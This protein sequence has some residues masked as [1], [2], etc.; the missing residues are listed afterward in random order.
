MVNLQGRVVFS[1]VVKLT[2]KKTNCL[3]LAKGIRFLKLNGDVTFAT[4]KL[5]IDNF[6]VNSQI[7]Y[8]AYKY[9]K[10]NPFRNAVVFL[11]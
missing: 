2:G 7:N 9:E 3:S 1:S 5:I 6:I 10:F 8:Y 4:Q 11:S